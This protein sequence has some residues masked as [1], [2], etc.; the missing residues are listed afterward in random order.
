MG[1]HGR[2]RSWWHQWD[3]VDVFDLDFGRAGWFC[4]SFPKMARND[5]K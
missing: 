3:E 4:K 2:R 1:H 5:L